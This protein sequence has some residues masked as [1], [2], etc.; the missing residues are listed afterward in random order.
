MGI[1][2]RTERSMERAMCE[3]QL[4]DSNGVKDSMLML[5]LNKTIVQLAVANSFHWYGHVLR[6]EDGHVLRRAYKFEVM[7]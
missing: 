2:Q 3:V 7:G 6:R 5:G 1:L 4:K